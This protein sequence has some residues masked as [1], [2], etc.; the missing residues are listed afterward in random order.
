M[1]WIDGLLRVRVRLL[2]SLSLSEAKGAGAQGRRGGKA[3]RRDKAYFSSIIIDL[4][5]KG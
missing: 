5:L 3:G 1:I 4:R 2:S